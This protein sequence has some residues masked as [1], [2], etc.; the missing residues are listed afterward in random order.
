MR[1]Q[2]VRSGAAPTRPVRRD[3]G[4]MVFGH[5]NAHN[6]SGMR[7]GKASADMSKAF[8]REDDGGIEALPDLPQ[9]ANPNYITPAGLAALRD[10]LAQAEARQE[11]FRARRD[12][13]AVGLDLAKAERDV[14]FLRE[15]IRRGIEIDPKSQPPGVVAFGA[16]VEVMDADGTTSVFRIVG[17]DEADAAAGRISAFSPL[18][19]VLLGGRVGDVADWNRPKGRTS[20]EILAISFP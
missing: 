20:L 5:A 17:E 3:G 10:R 2:K 11:D 9:S 12:E 13:V 7:A 15:R 4:C 16:E 18:A 8:T 1:A 19:R 6:V 14:R